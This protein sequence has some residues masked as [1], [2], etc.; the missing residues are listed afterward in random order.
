MFAFSQ[1]CLAGAGTDNAR[2][3]KKKLNAY[4]HRAQLTGLSGQNWT[5]NADSTKTMMFFLQSECGTRKLYQTQEKTEQKAKL[6]MLLR[7]QL[8]LLQ[9]DFM[10]LSFATQEL[11]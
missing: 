1:N 5:K 9:N 8:R 6:K 7:P 4:K 10:L 2:E 3:K 11:H